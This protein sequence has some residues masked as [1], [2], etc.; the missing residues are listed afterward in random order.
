MK[1]N[2]FAFVA[3]AMVAGI[4]ASCTNDEDVTT[5]ITGEPRI[6]PQ[7]AIDYKFTSA[8]KFLEVR[9]LLA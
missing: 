1:K 5:T 3:L 8:V 7:R 9:L 4:F 2:K 6:A